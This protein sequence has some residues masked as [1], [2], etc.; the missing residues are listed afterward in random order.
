MEEKEL[1]ILEIV[2]DNPSISQRKIAEKTGVSLGQVNFLL[3]KFVKKGLIKIEGQ[4]SKSIQYNLT[5]KGLKEKAEKTLNYIKI[6]YGAVMKMSARI[7]EI[8][9]EQLS[10]GKDIYILGDVDEIYGLVGTILKEMD[11]KFIYLEDISQVIDKN[12]S[13][14]LFWDIC[15]EEKIKDFNSLNI[16]SVN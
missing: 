8:T 16:I 4:S 12:N 9:E 14:I 13:C 1:D 2:A 5:P 10:L 6:S 3:K 11:I 7:K 15:N